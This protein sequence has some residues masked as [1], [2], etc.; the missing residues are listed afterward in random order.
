MKPVNFAGRS[1]AFAQARQACSQEREPAGGAH[2]QLD[3]PVIGIERRIATE[4]Q[5]VNL[6][7]AFPQSPSRKPG[8]SGD[9][10]KTEKPGV[11][12]GDETEAHAGSFKRLCR[13]FL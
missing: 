4:N 6:V 10:A 13:L 5:N 3:R 7:S 1:K 11:G 2:V 12:I 9:S 8:V